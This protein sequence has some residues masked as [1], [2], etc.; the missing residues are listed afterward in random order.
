MSATEKA[1]IFLVDDTET[2]IDV[3]IEILSDQYDIGV[4]LDGENALE[5]IPMTDPDLILLDIMMPGIDG[6]EVCRR[7]KQNPA[8]ENIPIIFVTAKQEILDETKG[9]SVGAVDYITKPISPPVVQA[10]IKTHLEL[11]RSRKQLASQ[12]TILEKK[13][14]ERTQ[15]LKI[16]NAELETTRLQ[17]IQRLGRAAEFKDN[18][19]G[20]HVIRMSHYSQI[21]ARAAGL[22]DER[23]NILLQAAPMHDIGKIGTPDRILLKPEK[24]NK[25]EVKIM[26]L[27]PDMGAG[28]IGNHDSILLKTARTVALTHHERWDGGGYPK[29]L[30]GEDIPVEGRI[31]AIADVFDALT[32]VRPYK[33]AWS[34]ESTLDFLRQEQ[35][36]HFDPNLVSLFI[37]AIDKVLEIHEK[38]AEKIEF[39]IDNYR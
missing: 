39:D 17:I 16:K 34:I 1:K 9:F 13:V 3:L 29:R 15:Q 12:N 28:I 38:W 5:D 27:H 32:T 37:S 23:A 22:G 11:V 8:T 7:L 19:T 30:K 31:A 18:E 21:L 6:Y 24:L 4:A 10:R 2:N 33:N 26:Q 20:L 36:K 14:Q 25:D 35:G